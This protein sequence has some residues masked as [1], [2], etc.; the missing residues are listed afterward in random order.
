MKSIKEIRRHNLGLVLDLYCERNQTIA[1][2]KLGYSTPSLVN[3][4]ITGSKAIGDGTARKIEETFALQQFWMDTDHSTSTDTPGKPS[5]SIDVR[6]HAV[7][8]AGH[9][10]NVSDV[11]IF[12]G[13]VPLIS[14]VQAGAWGEGDFASDDAESWLMCPAPHSEHTFALTVRGISMEPK[15][16]DGDVIYVDPA[17][18]PEHGKNVVVRMAGQEQAT[19]RHLVVEGDKMFL[20]TLNP[21]WPGPK[22][23]ELSSD[24]EIKGVVIGRYVPE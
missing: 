21:D 8:R 9:E 11:T 20:Q 1:A 7:S 17:V 15:Y 2:N 23:V 19:F 5:V 6:S 18:L 24:D 3:R 12:K 10:A 14:W 22:L 16:R 13:E 4:Y